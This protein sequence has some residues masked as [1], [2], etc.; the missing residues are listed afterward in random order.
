M[1]R[2]YQSILADHFANNRQMAF[3][4][5]PRQVGKT[6]LAH[7]A[8]PHA[9]FFSYDNPSDARSIAA[10]PDR[11]AAA[12]DLANPLR[13]R[14]GVVFGEL[15]KFPRWK[16]FLKGFCDIHGD[17]LPVVVTGS[18]RLDVYKRGG[19]SLMG[20]YFPFRVHPLTLGELASADF[21]FETE[22]RPPRP[23]PPDALPSLLRFGGFPEPFL[24]GSQRF[25]NQW[26]RLRLERLFHEDLRDLSRVQ[27]L[28]GL[29][30][31]AEL[32]APRIGSGINMA[33]LA[34]DL[35]VSPDTVKAWLAILESVYWCFPVRPWFRNVANSIRKQPKYY[36]WDWSL[37]PAGGPRAENLV[38]SHLLK[39]VHAWTDTGLGDYSLHYLRNKQG[40]EIDFLV[41]QDNVPF[42]LVECKSSAGAPLSPALAH[43]QTRLSVPYAFQVALAAPPS[44]LD[45]RTLLHRPAKLSAPDLL[46]I[47]P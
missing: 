19:D 47:L 32:L 22:F 2:I 25:W 14:N 9:A 40:I 39:A 44:A 34:A 17:G 42:L 30:T 27:D 21:G 4:S 29:R 8:L 35:A 16:S 20:R 45:P 28:R 36:L 18:A 3:L 24:K 12:A 10:G 46:K 5:G 33:G 1:K 13:V 7:A 43:F 23:V 11:V 31:L 15:H 6:T 26:K 41:A 38:A 37:A